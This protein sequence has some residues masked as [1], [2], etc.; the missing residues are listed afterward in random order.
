MQKPIYITFASP[1]GGVGK[2]TLTTLMASYLHYTKE[3][4]VAVIDC[5]YPEYGLDFL[6]RNE[7]EKITK[8]NYYNRKA[9]K[10]FTAKNKKAYPVINTRVETAIEEAE[11]LQGADII[12]FDM[13]NIMSGKAVSLFAEMECIVF[14]LMGGTMYINT[15]QSFV[16]AINQLVITTGKGKIKAMYLL[17][18]RVNNW[19]GIEFTTACEALAADTGTTLLNSTLSYSR[20]Y[21]KDIFCSKK[22]DICVSTL[23]PF[24]KQLPCIEQL[25]GFM[26]E[27]EQ[28]VGKL[29]GK[30]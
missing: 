9:Q 6:R 25:R 10:Q 4:N 17:R 24:D 11:K 28:I 12:L 19:D 2:T 1:K 23:F 5:C 21:Q 18:N 8:D 7:I 26:Q 29:C 30:Y 27:M 14:P 15:L 16:E 20:H 13:P 22:Q 3:Y